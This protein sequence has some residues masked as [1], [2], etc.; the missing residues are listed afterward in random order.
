MTSPDPYGHVDDFFGG[1]LPSI[2]FDE[3]KGYVRG[4]PKG[5]RILAIR[6][7]QQQTDYKTKK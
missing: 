6:P 3:R 4:T 2:S 5:G 1:G 7:K